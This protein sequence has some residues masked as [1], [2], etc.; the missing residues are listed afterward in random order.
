[1]TN[2][3]RRLKKGIQSLEEQIEIHR[4]K[5]RKAMEDGNEDLGDYYNKEIEKFEKEIGKKESKF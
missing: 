5:R 2:R 1:M 4:V 3:K